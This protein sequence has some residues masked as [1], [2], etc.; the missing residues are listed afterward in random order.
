MDNW[1]II[2]ELVKMKNE[3]LLK[4]A[5]M[6]RLVRMVQPKSKRLFNGFRLLLNE[7]G[8]ILIRWG[9]FLQKR[10]TETNHI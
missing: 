10:Y 1:L 9:S 8:K 5:E 7:L 3:Q 6:E 4:E 2:W